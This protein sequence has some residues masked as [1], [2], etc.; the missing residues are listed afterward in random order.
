M[1]TPISEEE[2]KAIICHA[3][4]MLLLKAEYNMHFL[5]YFASKSR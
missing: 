2:N 3:S 5:F 4:V 1:N